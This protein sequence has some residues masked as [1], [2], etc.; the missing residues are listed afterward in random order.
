MKIS[1]IDASSYFKGLLLLVRKD[2]KITEPEINVMKR[3][4]KTLGFEKEFCDSAINEILDNECI[5][6][7]PSMFS[8]KDIAVKF[9]KDGFSLALSD[10]EIHAAE[11]E[12]LKATAE[13]NNLDFEWFIREKET[14][15]M[16]K[17]LSNHLEAEDFVIEYPYYISK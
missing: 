13:K 16:K 2:K 17:D 9:I 15:I 10:N 11:E 3:I 4:G 5:A 14:S 1:I 8:N 7:T 6:D 12:W